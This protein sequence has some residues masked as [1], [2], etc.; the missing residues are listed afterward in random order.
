MNIAPGGVLTGS[1]S[2]SSTYNNGT[3]D[4]SNGSLKVQGDYSQGHNGVLN[5]YIDNQLDISGNAMLDGAVNLVNQNYV[6]KG[7]TTFCMHRMFRGNL[8]S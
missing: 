3:I 1:G 7:I 2:V 8:T 4:L 5:A 6:V